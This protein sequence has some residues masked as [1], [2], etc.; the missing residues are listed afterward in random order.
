[1]K[2]RFKILALFTL[3]STTQL[4]IVFFNLN[5]QTQQ[6]KNSSSSQTTSVGNN[7]N[8]TN[9]YKNQSASSSDYKNQNTSTNYYYQNYSVD[10]YSIPTLKA[11]KNIKK[12]YDNERKIFDKDIN[13]PAN[14]IE[15]ENLLEF[16][17]IKKSTLKE[18]DNIKFEN[19]SKT[20]IMSYRK[21]IENT[22]ITDGIIQFEKIIHL[23]KESDQSAKM[24]KYGQITY[25]IVGS[26]FGFLLFKFYTNKFLYRIKYVEEM[27]T[28]VNGVAQFDNNDDIEK[29]E[30][31]TDVINVSDFENDAL[32]KT[33]TIAKVDALSDELAGKEDWI[34]EDAWLFSALDPKEG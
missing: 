1:M 20:D 18:F 23:A 30:A 32:S 14:R 11:K 16:L 5:A 17:K 24:Y 26:L 25:L 15:Y 19:S 33:L 31:N 4:P 12:V 28:I 29:S 22:K 7:Q 6:V 21:Q 27:P 9:D 13:I 10:N 34:N 2:N 3:V 8:V